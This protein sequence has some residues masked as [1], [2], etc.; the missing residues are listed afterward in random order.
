MKKALVDFGAALAIA[1]VALVILNGNLKD[2]E[3]MQELT[4]EKGGVGFEQLDELVDLSARF[5]EGFGQL[6]AILQASPSGIELI[7]VYSPDQHRTFWQVVDVDGDCRM[8][9]DKE[10]AL[11]DFEALAARAGR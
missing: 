9:G 4:Y 11:W 5:C 1:G 10:S 2:Y 3:T 8:H 6:E 7:E